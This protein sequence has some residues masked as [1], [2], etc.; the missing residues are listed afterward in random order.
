MVPSYFEF[1]NSVKILSGNKALENVPYELDRLG[2][3]KPIIITDKGVVAAGLIKEFIGA[4]SGSDLV[5]GA[6]YE[7]TPPD[8]SNVVVNQVAGIYRQNN[9]D[10]IIAIGGGSA[11]DTAKGVNIVITEE[12]DDLMKFIGAERL[13]KK[14]K[15]FVVIPTTAGTG[16]EATLVAVIANVEKN[17]KMLFTSYMLLPD[18]AVLDP[19]MTMTMPPKITAGTGMDALTHAVEAYT[20]L[21]KNPVS[22]GFAFT[23]IRLISK[24]LFK[25]VEN[26]KDSEARM[27]M[28][29]AA[30]LAGIAFSNSMVGIVHT[31][32]HAC[33]AVGHVPHGYAMALLLPFGMEYNM[34]KS[35]DLYAE[36]LLPLAGSE[37]FAA[38]PG[39]RRA[40]RSVEVIREM[41]SKLNKLTGMPVTLREAGVKREQFHEIAKTALGD[42]SQIFNP[43]AID[44]NDVLNILNAAY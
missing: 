21:Q 42:G 38:T 25:A 15:P 32:G 23:A 43:E 20:C 14:M 9:C 44:Y 37:E 1:Y 4:L 41:N 27:A 19:R 39:E 31:I 34:K 13:K 30:L 16:S 11:I 6:I 33:G 5:I 7:D 29:N 2:A 12:T 35:S 40:A 10:S 18:V 24:N 3:K 26:G 36:L 28:A 22:D 8:S 17:C